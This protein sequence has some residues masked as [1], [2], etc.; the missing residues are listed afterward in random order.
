MLKQ[1][2]ETKKEA[3]ENVK[4]KGF[5]IHQIKELQRKAKHN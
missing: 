2:N 1:L 5:F 3:K 4:R